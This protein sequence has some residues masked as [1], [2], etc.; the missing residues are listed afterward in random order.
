[1]TLWH[2]HYQ[3]TDGEIIGYEN[4]D[5]PSKQPGCSILSVE[6]DENPTGCFNNALYKVDIQNLAII[7]KTDAEKGKKKIPSDMDIRGLIAMELAKTDTFMILDRP[8]NDSVREAWKDYRQTLRDLS[9]IVDIN[10]RIAA[11]PIRPDGIDAI[12]TFRG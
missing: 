1:M 2:V 3:T 7:A 8:M 11:W 9:K 10:E 12:P 4:C 6:T 5:P